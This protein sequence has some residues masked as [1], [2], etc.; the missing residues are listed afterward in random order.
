ML[1]TFKKFLCALQVSLYIKTKYG[2][3]WNRHRQLHKILTNCC[4]IKLHVKFEGIKTI[5]LIIKP[6]TVPG[7]Y[8]LALL[9][10]MCVKSQIQC[11]N[12]L[13]N[14]SA[15]LKVMGFKI[16]ATIG[17][18]FWLWMLQLLWWKHN[19]LTIGC[20]TENLS[21]RPRIFIG[22][23]HHMIMIIIIINKCII[24]FYPLLM[25]NC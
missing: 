25:L 2:W 12:G 14:Y 1:L 7:E 4:V 8:W 21:N 15:D 16:K 19:V 13:K 3:W 6:F 23:F 20:S 10:L 18:E 11:P 9:L 5:I 22:F 24:Y 17:G